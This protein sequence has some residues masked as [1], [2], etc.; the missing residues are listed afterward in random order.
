[1]SPA[2]GLTSSSP[3]TSSSSTRA[4]RLKSPARRLPLL[5]KRARRGGTSLDGHGPSTRAETG[6][7]Q[8]GRWIRVLLG[9]LPAT[10]L[11]LP[12]LFAGGAGAAIAFV[13]GL[14]EPGRSLAE[15]WASASTAGM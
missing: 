6:G 11:L 8:V 15:R 7:E 10:V 1:M 5:C 2:T 14:V 13:A 12:L 9:P 3:R 4:S